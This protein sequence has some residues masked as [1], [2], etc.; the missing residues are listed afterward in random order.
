M[1]SSICLSKNGSCVVTGMKEKILIVDDEDSIRDICYRIL[2]LE[3]YDVSTSKNYQ[4][5]MARIGEICFDLIF[6]DIKLG[7]KTGIEILEKVKEMKL[8]SLVI[9]FTGFPSLETASQA[10]RLGAFEYLIKP[11]DITLLRDTAEKALRHKLILQERERYRSNLEAIFMS[12]DDAIISVDK[13]LNV[14]EINRAAQNICGIRREAVIGNNFS[15]MQTSCEGKCLKILSET[16]K[17]RKPMEAVRQVCGQKNRP[18]QVITIRTYPLFNAYNQFSG[19]VLVAKD[20]TYIVDLE[21]DLAERRQSQNLIGKSKKMQEIYLLIEKLAKVPTT[22]LITGEN[23]TGKE[24]VAEAIHYSGHR[25]DKPLVKLNCCALTDDLLE[26]ELFGH[27]K[28]AFTG[29]IENKVGRFQKAHRGTLFLDEIGDISQRMQLRLLRVLQT[30]EF[31]P[32]GSST[33]LKVDV[34]F[35]AATNRDLMKKVRSG[36][37]REDLY[38]RLKV[39]EMSLPPLRDRLEDIPLLV[40]HFLKKFNRKL[41]KNV[42]QISSEV[43]GKFMNYPWPGNVREL[44]HTLEH[45]VILC[46][47]PCIELQDIP[48]DFLLNTFPAL[49]GGNPKPKTTEEVLAAL[50]EAGWNKAKAARFLGISRHT[51]YKKILKYNLENPLK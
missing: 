48:K 8:D 24:M 28:G 37:F 31:E 13:D 47:G 49:N 5:A 25:K 40:D 2:S 21:Q 18:K 44:E 50:K 34:R 43:L 4:D 36:Q 10:L 12:V 42:D 41:K 45:A 51:L 17:N 14:I 15:S 6:V 46:N 7:G 32:V 19:A 27:I 16:V 29:A 1:N 9:I 23:G 3:G 35:L 39:M 33:P 26:S 20:E 30:Q 11:L 38:Y 22:V